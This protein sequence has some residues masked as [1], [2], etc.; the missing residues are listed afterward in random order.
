M[1]QE[2]QNTKDTADTGATAS[3][4]A[5]NTPDSSAPTEAGAGGESQTFD[6]LMSAS[7]TLSPLASWLKC[8]R[9]PA[10]SV[11]YSFQKRHVPDLDRENKKGGHTAS[12]AKNTASGSTESAKSGKNSDVMDVTGSFTIRYFDFALGILGMAIASCMAKGCGCLKRKMH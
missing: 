2:N 12:G 1:E 3:S 6:Q 4:A 11:E 9:K 10:I 7:P 8:L 5:G